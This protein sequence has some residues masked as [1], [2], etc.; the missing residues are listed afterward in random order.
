ML[1]ME[2]A[3]EKLNPDPEFPLNDPEMKLCV[4]LL[5][6]ARP[7]Y[8]YICLDALFK[9]SVFQENRKPDVFLY[10]DVMPDGKNYI[11]EIYALTHDLPIENVFVNK[12]HE[13][14]APTYWKAFNKAFDMG[15]DYCLMLEEDWL[16]TSDSLKWLYECPKIASHYSLYR[17]EDRIGQSEENT[18]LYNGENLS[19]CCA[20]SKDSFEFI[21][22]I[23]KA[24]A[25]YGLFE[26]PLTMAQLRRFDYKDWD[27][28]LSVIFRHYKLTSLAPPKS[29]LAHF[30]SRTS[31]Y[32][33]FGSD[34][35]INL[36]E[37]PKEQWLDN[38]SK[39]LETLSD[40]EKDKHAIR[41]ASFRY[42]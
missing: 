27:A 18:V 1:G 33:G 3:E 4:N 16:I 25:Y 41:P 12:K 36:F 2:L 24:K 22:N 29:L 8:L 17:W 19:W 34:K 5:T 26:K 14:I 38:L 15:Y 13:G 31:N 20:F 40:E 30:G 37:G 42:R 32:C 35:A 11:K 28:I 7:G 39:V 10:V 23:I 21:Y 6:A 9:N